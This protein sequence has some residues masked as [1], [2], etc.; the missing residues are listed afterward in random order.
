MIL[1]AIFMFLM[2]LG[3]IIL[4]FIRPLISAILN[5]IDTLPTNTNSANGII[6]PNVVELDTIC[7]ENHRKRSM[8]IGFTIVNPYAEVKSFM[9]DMFFSFTVGMTF[10]CILFLS[11]YIPNSNKTHALVILNTITLS[12]R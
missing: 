3:L 9:S 7:H 2:M 6:A 4:F 5:C 8:V 12:C 11:M 1:A 10:I